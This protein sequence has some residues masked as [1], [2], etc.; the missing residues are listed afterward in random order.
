M[1][2]HL[3]YGVW[4]NMSGEER[5]NYDAL[6]DK[7][8]E[9]TEKFNKTTKE[10]KQSKYD[11]SFWYNEQR[12]AKSVTSK[13][14]PISIR[15]LKEK[16]EYYLPATG[17]WESSHLPSYGTINYA[18]SL[19]YKKLIKYGEE[20]HKKLKIEHTNLNKE[21][22]KLAQEFK[23]LEQNLNEKHKTMFLPV[24]VTINEKYAE[25]HSI[26][27]DENNKAI[28]W[29]DVNPN[30][31]HKIQVDRYG[32]CFIIDRENCLSIETY[33]EEQLFNTPCC[34]EYKD[35]LREF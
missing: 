23:E 13:N 25:E 21:L 18:M 19:Y 27:V 22:S 16:N 35:A 3:N 2:Q 34:D 5:Q 10:L 12:Y 6:Y 14:Y 15:T 4:H 1:K 11:I 28:T 29:I 31:E 32:G 24:K 26:R 33:P 8:V 20:L 30:N 7:F 9:T 17:P